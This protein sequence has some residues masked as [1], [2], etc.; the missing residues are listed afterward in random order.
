[1]SSFGS[2]QEKNDTQYVQE[3]QRTH[4]LEKKVKQLEY[5]TFMANTLTQAKEDIWFN[6][7][8]SISEIWPFVKIVFG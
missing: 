4:R 3:M 1:M 7:A 5:Q 2:K 6:I 8:N